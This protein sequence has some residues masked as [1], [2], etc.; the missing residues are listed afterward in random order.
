MIPVEPLF[1]AWEKEL[2]GET[3]DHIISLAK[4]YE[5]EDGVIGGNDEKPGVVVKDKRNSG[6]RWIDDNFLSNAIFG[7]AT[8]A[9]DSSW[10][11]NVEARSSLQFTEYTVDQYY[12]WHMDTFMLE[13]G[14]R[15]LSII[16]QLTDPSD[17]EGGDFQF[18]LHGGQVDDVPMLRQR[19]TV[20]VFPSW[21]EHQVTP[22]TKGKRQ[23]LVA[24][25]SG[26][27]LV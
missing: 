5:L 17:Y 14:M 1:W 20:L 13:D 6:I 3:C 8:K 7:F 2:S 22:V 27:A 9:N 18:R 15:K 26:P 10:G 11:L 25:M 23:T 4:K 21:I 12:G 16:I 24:W 19:G